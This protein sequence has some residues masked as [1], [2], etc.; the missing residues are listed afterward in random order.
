MNWG[1]RCKKLN[2]ETLHRLCDLLLLY[3]HP[4]VKS[5]K[6]TKYDNFEFAGPSFIN[7]NI[8]IDFDAIQNYLPKEKLQMRHRTDAKLRTVYTMFIFPLI[9]ACITDD[10]IAHQNSYNL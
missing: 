3:D 5:I 7:H 8:G 9:Q 6:Y 2:S 1:N 4:I 10:E